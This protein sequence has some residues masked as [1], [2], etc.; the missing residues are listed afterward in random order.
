[1]APNLQRLV[2]VT[3]YNER[4][5]D[6]IFVERQI[7]T[8]PASVVVFF[9]GDVQDYPE[10]MKSHRDHG[11]YV[12]YNLE[13]VAEILA[14]KFKSSFICVIRPAKVELKTFSCFSNFVTC[15]DIGSPTHLP[16]HNALLHLTTLLLS[17]A[18]QTGHSEVG[19][20]SPLTIMG[21]SKGCVVLNQLLH[22]FHYFHHLPVDKESHI[23]AL[24]G[25]IRKMVWLDGGHSGGKDTWVTSSNVLS[26]LQ[27]TGIAV[28]IHVTPYQVNDDRRPWIGKEEK[29]FHTLLKKLGVVLFRKVHFAEEPPS[30]DNH[31]LLLKIFC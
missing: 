1:M 20:E 23:N 6:V 30:L 5:N 22:E 24:M 21:F 8:D 7:S 25:R 29:Q 18:E 10:N 26:S 27:S 4:V 16:N 9:G 12:E 17:V 15:N 2:A 3:G 19:C 11:V 31:F 28:D 14:S 13:A